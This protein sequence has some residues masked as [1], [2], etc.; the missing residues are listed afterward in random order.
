PV[1][2]RLRLRRGSAEHDRLAWRH[3]PDRLEERS[4]SCREDPQQ[5]LDDAVVVEGRR[6][7]ERA[8]QGLQIPR[9]P[10]AAG[11]AAVKQRSDAE[12]IAAGDQ[13]SL[14]SVPDDD[15]EVAG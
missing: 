11:R 2:L 5:V 15:G 6:A 8:Q 9:K 14:A 7:L 4:M 1:R 10:D 12:W 3:G 13:K